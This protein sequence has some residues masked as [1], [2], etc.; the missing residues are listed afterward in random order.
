MIVGWL[1]LWLGWLGQFEKQKVSFFPGFN[2]LQCC[3]TTVSRKTLSSGI[4]AFLT[5][6]NKVISQL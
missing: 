4:T 3:V 1:G 5:E 2:Y 6:N